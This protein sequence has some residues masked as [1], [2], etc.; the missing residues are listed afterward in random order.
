M[1][2]KYPIGTI[3]ERRSDGSIIY[4]SSKGVLNLDKPD[5]VRDRNTG[6]FVR[7]DSL[8]E[9]MAEDKAYLSN[10]P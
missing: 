10:E 6:R 4:M 1:M 2:R 3:I 7:Q 9:A 5:M 8:A